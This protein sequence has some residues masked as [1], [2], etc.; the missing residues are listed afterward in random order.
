MASSI[1]LIQPVIKKTNHLWRGHAYALVLYLSE[2]YPDS[3]IQFSINTG[4]QYPIF[5]IKSYEQLSS[6]HWRIVFNA[7]GLLGP[8][9]TLP[10]HDQST[11]VNQGPQVRQVVS[12]FFDIFHHR[13]LFWSFVSW[14]QMRPSLTYS[15]AI[16]SYVKQ[17]NDV[18]DTDLDRF[19]FSQNGRS[20]SSY[21]LFLQ[22][23]SGIRGPFD[24]MASFLSIETMLMPAGSTNAHALV[25][26]LKRYFN[27]PIF[28]KTF[29]PDRCLLS[30]DQQTQLALLG[31]NNQLGQTTILGQSVWMLSGQ[32]T[33]YIGPLN[34]EQFIDFIPGGDQL[35][36]FRLMVMRLVDQSL[37]VNVCLVVKKEAIISLKLSD[38]E[39]SRLGINM[40]LGHR[41]DQEDS[42][43][44]CFTL[45]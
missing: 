38:S 43:D 12:D 4:S 41:L 45:I 44:L 36:Y 16:G 28:L 14:R 32:C 23:L 35:E 10:S 6:N 2:R 42:T 19:I 30:I 5:D 20:T 25:T 31:R 7:A 1:S 40:W 34:R 27:L 15:L 33:L 3:F 18:L 13:L 39:E 29:I 9:A 22:S 24:E 8:Y 37:R 17:N 21:A 26:L 11:L